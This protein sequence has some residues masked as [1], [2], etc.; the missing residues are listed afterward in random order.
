MRVAVASTVLAAVLAVSGSAAGAATGPTPAQVSTA[1][2]RAERATTLWATINICDP[3]ADPKVLG[4]RGQMP[5][6]GFASWMS[7][8]IRLEYYDARRHRWIDDP[9][10]L[11][12]IRL[13]RASR[14]LQQGGATYAFTGPTPA[15][16]ARVRFAW[17]RS[18]RLLGTTVGLTTA[19]HPGA[20]YGS[21]P[22]YSAASCRIH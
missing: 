6:L 20:D 11:K 18:G 8:E 5:S 2:A 7:M 10:T 4:V 14:G 15:L 1:V 19:G 17:R 13:G 16:R 22:G 21:P 3:R 9:G 12:T